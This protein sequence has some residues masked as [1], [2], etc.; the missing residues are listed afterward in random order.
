MNP[1]FYLQHGHGGAGPFMTESVTARE[2]WRPQPRKG[3]VTAT[4]F[5][6]RW[7]GRWY[8]LYSDHAARNVYPH[9]IRTKDGRVHVSGVTP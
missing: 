1:T 5:K 4:R 8:R 3:C 2:D 7:R 6:V 9:F